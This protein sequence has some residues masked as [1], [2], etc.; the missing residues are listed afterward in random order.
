MNAETLA[1]RSNSSILIAAS[2]AVVGL[3]AATARAE[4]VYGVTQTQTL[5]TWDSASP[6]NILG[7]V[8]LNGLQSNE[9]IRGIDFRPATGQLYAL[10]STSRLYTVNIANGAATQVGAVLPTP[11]NGSNFGFDFNP[12]ID[13]IRVVSNQNQNLVLHP[14]TG[15]Q[16]A[17]TA[18]FFGNADVNFGVDPNVVHSA[19][20]NNFAGTGSTQLYGIDTNLDILVT[21]ANSAGTLGTVGSIGADINEI[22]GFDI[23]GVTGLAYAVTMDVNLSRSTFWTINLATGQGTM[24]GMIGQVGGGEIITAMSVTGAPV[25]A[26]A[27]LGLLATA[28]WVSRRRRSA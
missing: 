25:P 2:C 4:I 14:D 24:V 26:P 22:G 11:L 17:A 12:Q 19:Y 10:G 6:N 16:T 1:R 15:A 18:V 8:A 9:V 20:S 13:R 7:G 3:A 21:Q 23:S 5:V 27:A 28:G